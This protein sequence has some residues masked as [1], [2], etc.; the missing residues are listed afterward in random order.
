MPCAINADTHYSDMVLMPIEII[1]KIERIF[2][3][4]YPH[5]T[6][7]RRVRRPDYLTTVAVKRLTHRQP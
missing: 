1:K 4:Q 6:N 7:N 3:S 5:V 2:H